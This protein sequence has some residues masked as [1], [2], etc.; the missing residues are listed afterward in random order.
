MLQG[1][2]QAVQD[3]TVLA[4]IKFPAGLAEVQAKAEK[5]SKNAGAVQHV[6]CPQTSA[7]SK[8]QRRC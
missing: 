2:I 4:E 1:H 6:S 8:E 5:G 7:T 3:M